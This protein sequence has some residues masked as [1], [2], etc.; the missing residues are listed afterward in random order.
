LPL[1]YTEPV[2]KE[3]ENYEEEDYEEE[4]EE[5]EEVQEQ[6]GEEQEHEEEHGGGQEARDK[7]Q[8]T[9]AERPT[10]DVRDGEVGAVQNTRRAEIRMPQHVLDRAA[11]RH[12][13]RVKV[14]FVY[15]AL[16]IHCAVTAS[17]NVS[18]LV[19]VAS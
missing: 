6:E 12:R 17:S 5:E 16:R 8:G 13:R 10:A 19:Q 4:E 2:A 3:E 14:P 18:M 15:S 11:L 7:G 1:P 9:R